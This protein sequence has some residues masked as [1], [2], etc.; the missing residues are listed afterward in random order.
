MAGSRNTVES[1]ELNGKAPRDLNTQQFSPQPLSVSASDH[2]NF[3][4]V[5]VEVSK[6]NSGFLTPRVL[7]Q[8]AFDELSRTLRG[9]VKDART[10]TDE[11]SQTIHQAEERD[12]ASMG[13][14]QQ[15]Q[16]QIRLSA[17]LLKAVQLQ[18][19]TLS[20]ASKGAQETAKNVEPMRETLD[21]HYA[22]FERRV[23]SLLAEAEQRIAAQLE[24][25]SNELF[26]ARK[27][28]LLRECDDRLAELLPRAE[29][30]CQMVELAEVNIAAL[31]HR[32]AENV[33]AADETAGRCESAAAMLK[34]ILQDADNTQKTWT[35]VLNQFAQTVGDVLSKQSNINAESEV[36]F[37]PAMLQSMV[38][39]LRETISRDVRQLH[40]AMQDIASRVNSLREPARIESSR[41]L[42]AVKV[43][44]PTQTVQIIEGAD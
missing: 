23:E 22:E 33:R 1:R 14:A 21:G 39:Q 34:S 40:S 36:K 24:A 5:S 31:A 13:S 15:L 27:D 19:E 9:L 35:I 18:S 41:L 6:D 4:G 26:N 11:L 37:D 38:E 12:R 44:T 20:N 42:N 8:R 16:E 10:A 28:E 3:A 30:L 43:K 32:S 29:R 17:R 25:R 7:D 2:G